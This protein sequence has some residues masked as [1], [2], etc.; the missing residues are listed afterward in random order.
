MENK[1]PDIVID[2]IID[3]PSKFGDV[4]IGDVTILKYAYLEKLKSPFVNP[5]TSFSVENIIPS[6]YVLAV[7]KSVLKQY[8]A[9]LE[10]LKLDALDWADDN[11]KL[12][13]V[14]DIIKCV[15]SKFTTVNKAAPTDV[16]DGKKIDEGV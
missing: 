15:V 8:G 14:P 1:N 6:V 7:E 13:D 5:E 11:L 10:R 9:D 12:D 2:A 3:A 16:G 4:T